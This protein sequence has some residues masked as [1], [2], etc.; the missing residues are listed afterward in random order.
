MSATP[1]V[2]RRGTP[3]ADVS[4]RPKTCPV[5]ARG[6][7]RS[8]CGSRS[9]RIPPYC[10]RLFQSL[11]RKRPA[12]RATGPNSSDITQAY[13]L[14]VPEMSE[15]RPKRQPP[16]VPA[17]LGV[18]GDASV[19]YVVTGSAAA[20][21]HGVPLVP[22]DL[23]ITPALDVENLMR[24]AVVLE[25]IEARQDPLAPFGHWERGDDGE[26]HWVETEPTPDAV[27]ARAS[28]HRTPPTRRR[29]TTSCSQDMAHSMLSQ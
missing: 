12:P 11:S 8:P 23:D 5:A 10:S 6:R 22:G 16:D 29:S 1:F 19:G 28:G 24:L 15:D 17:L 27:A 2:I 3:P 7:S 9:G 25:S 26:R 20:M 13:D 14:A 21:L 4:R 18:L